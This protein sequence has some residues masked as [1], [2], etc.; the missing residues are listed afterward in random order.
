MSEPVYGLLEV[1]DRDSDLNYNVRLRVMRSGL[2]RNDWDYRNIEQFAETFKGTPIL[3]AYPGNRIGD[4][5]NF[6][7]ALWNGEIICDFTGPNAERIVGAIGEG[8]NDVWTETG[9]DGTWIIANGKLWRF[10]NRQLCDHLAEQGRMEVSAETEVTEEHEESG[11]SV[12]TAWRGL[13]V[14]I[15]HETVAPAIPGASIQAL[16]AMNSEK[17]NSLKLKVASYHPNT[18]GGEGTPPKAE[19]HEPPK[20]NKGVEKKLTLNK[21]QLAKLN[22]RFAG[23]VLLQAKENE[24]DKSILVTMRNDSYESFSYRLA[25]MDETIAPERIV[26]VPCT[27]SIGEDFAMNAEDYFAALST[28]VETLSDELSKAQKERDDAQ[29]TIKAMTEKE[30]TRRVKA[31]KEAAKSALDK[32]NADRSA[33]EKVCEEDIS[34][35]MAEID[36][37]DYTECAD[38]DGNFCGEEKV[39][40]R[41]MSICAQKD[42][43]FR[44]KNAEKKNNQFAWDGITAPKGDDGTVGALLRG[45]N[46]E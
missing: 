8:E 28:R 27:V 22:E 36:G 4:G 19:D 10:Y 32:F 26:P 21:K 13:G 35:V 18:E 6:D 45:L 31:M 43:E 9:E 41:V 16:K 23:Y 33:E 25:S 44:A 38:K 3:C 30:N 40:Q 7:E 46:I 11:I 39:C 42:M 34:C 12:F 14:T 15:L 37:G 20:N 29:A 1:L 2:N 5:H 24:E 17:W